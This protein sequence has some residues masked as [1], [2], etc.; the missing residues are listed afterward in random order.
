MIRGRLRPLTKNPDN[1]Q[2]FEY[3]PSSGFLPS[4]ALGTLLTT[5]WRADLGRCSVEDRE[6]RE[7]R[8]FRDKISD[9]ALRIN[10]DSAS[11]N[12]LNSLN[13]LISLLLRP[14]IFPILPA[15]FAIFPHLIASFSCYLQFFYYLCPPKQASMGS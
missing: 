9:W 5:N 8:E 11:L 14:P 15:L 4:V 3:S 12:S 10:V 13:S 6:D 1:E 7:N 2:Y